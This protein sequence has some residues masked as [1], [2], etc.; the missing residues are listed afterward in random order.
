MAALQGH[1]GYI[2][3]QFCNG[4]FFTKWIYI[5]RI[6]ENYFTALYRIGEN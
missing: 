5:G 3:S 4:I 2:I 1:V 6:I